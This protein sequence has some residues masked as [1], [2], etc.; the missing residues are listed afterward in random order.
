M[1]QCGDHLV[2]LETVS[3]LQPLHLFP[4]FSLTTTPLNTPTTKTTGAP[5]QPPLLPPTRSA[6]HT[7]L[8]HL[9]KPQLCSPPLP[10]PVAGHWPQSL[11]APSEA[12]QLPRHSVTSAQSLQG[13]I[14]LSPHPHF[15]N[16]ETRVRRPAPCSSQGDSAFLWAT[17]KAAASCQGGYE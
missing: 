2:K 4:C 7:R 3:Q 15:A 1:C 11:T 5:L 14:P 16:R 8:H 13:W 17:A 12:A 9:P 6:C 10:L